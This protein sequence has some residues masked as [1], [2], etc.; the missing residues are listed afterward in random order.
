MG[1]LFYLFFIYLVTVLFHGFFFF[2]PSFF[3]LFL[4]SFFFISIGALGRGN[5][6]YLLSRSV[7]HFSF[8]SL[9]LYKIY[10]ETI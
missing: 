5:F 1:I 8:F 9:F 10:I 2:F 6:H 7:C 3:S 4:L